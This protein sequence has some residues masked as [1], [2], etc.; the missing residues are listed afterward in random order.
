MLLSTRG[1]HGSHR[2]KMRRY[3]GFGEATEHPDIWPRDRRGSI[4]C[5]CDAHFTRLLGL[6]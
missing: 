3:S 1:R 2:Q 5:Q 6:A 4:F